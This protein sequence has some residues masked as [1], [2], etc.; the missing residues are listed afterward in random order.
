MCFFIKYQRKEKERE[1][2]MEARKIGREWKGRMERKECR[3]DFT[4]TI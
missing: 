3:R 4:F 2:T 1:G